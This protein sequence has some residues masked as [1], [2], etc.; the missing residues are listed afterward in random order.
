MTRTPQPRPPGRPRTTP[1]LVVSQA[2][3]AAEEPAAQ[4]ENEDDV[5]AGPP[6]TDALSEMMAG[7]QGAANSRISIYRILKNQPPSYVAE[8]APE[9]F[10]LDDLRDKYNGGE[11][12]LYVMKDGR[13][14]KNMRVFV[15]APPSRHDPVAASAPGSLGDLLTVM[16]EGFAA[17]AA[18]LREAAAVRPAAAPMFSGDNLPAIITAVTG[19]L[20]ALRPP[21]PPPAPPPAAD[22]DFASKSIDMFMK[23]LELARDLK[24]DASPADNSIGGMLRTVLGSPLMAQAVA[25]ATPQPHPPQPRPA[26]AGPQQPQAQTQPQ[27]QPQPQAQTQPTQPEAS[28]VNMLHYYYGLLCQKAA[29]GADPTLYAEM[30]LDNVDDDTLNTLLTKQPTPLDA[31]IAEYPA[32]APHREWF[33]QLIDVLMS[34][35]TEEEPPPD[36]PQPINGAHP[37]AAHVP[38]PVVPGQPS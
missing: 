28:D 9:S 20:V 17:Q 22:V 11:F 21:P 19:A 29:A 34:A 35:M 4:V 36:V 15:E 7:L 10:S 1:Q 14:W 13:L 31:L 37:D 24:E 33:G 6:P 8:C 26:L 23:G 30:V 25:A 5:P 18:A 3:T 38:P 32:A 27:P 12:R 16:R 2:K